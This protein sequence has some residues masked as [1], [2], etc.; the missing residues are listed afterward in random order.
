MTH[1]TI[2]APAVVATDF[3]ARVHALMQLH[4]ET[5]PLTRAVAA[6][7]FLEQG[8]MPTANRIRQLIGS[9]SMST[10]SNELTVF[11]E[12]VRSQAKLRLE[13]AQVPPAVLTGFADAVASAWQL[14]LTSAQTQSTAELAHDRAAFESEQA[15][16]AEA[17]AAE[18]QEHIERGS[19]LDA[20]RAAA[21]EAATAVEAVETTMTAL[22]EE[23]RASQAAGVAAAETAAQRV[24]ALESQLVELEGKRSALETRLAQQHNDF[25]TR[26]HAQSEHQRALLLQVDGARQAQKESAAALRTTERELQDAR[27]LVTTLQRDLAA[28]TQKEV[29]ASARAREA[30]EAVKAARAETGQ[31]EAELRAVRAQ[32]RQ[33][34]EALLRLIPPAKRPASPSKN[35]AA[36]PSKRRARTQD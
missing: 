4:S 9:G 10:I 3:G 23:L 28:M 13:H 19:A 35:A 30:Q 29:G 26:E 7:L 27:T 5:R 25:V 15:R 31:V 2:A 34:Q 21:A 18:R 20:A 33:D 16:T 8:E 17:L 32:A 12:Q 36:P 11:W 1:G 14:A 6:L 22:R 24:A